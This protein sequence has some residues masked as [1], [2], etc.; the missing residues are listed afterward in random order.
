[1]T[2]KTFDL[3][4]TELKF[5][6]SRWGKRVNFEYQP[7]LRELCLKSGVRYGVTVGKGLFNV[8]KYACK[9]GRDDQPTGSA[10]EMPIRS[11][12]RLEEVDGALREMIAAL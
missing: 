6:E 9:I 5:I 4:P 1:M 8:N 12:L 2:F 10:D 11:G 7:T 3:T